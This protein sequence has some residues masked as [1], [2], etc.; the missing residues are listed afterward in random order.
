MVGAKAKKI[1]S[2][3][4]ETYTSVQ[5][6]AVCV[7]GPWVETS[8]K[9]GCGPDYFD[10]KYSKTC[11]QVQ[12][13]LANST[14]K[15]VR[16]YGNYCNMM[17]TWI[18]ALWCGRWRWIHCAV[19][20]SNHKQAPGGKGTS[21][22]NHIRTNSNN[23]SLQVSSSALNLKD[24][25]TFFDVIYLK[26]IGYVLP[27]S[28]FTE[29]ALNSIQSSAICSFIPKCGFNR[30]THRPSFL[31]P[32]TLPALASPPSTLSKMRAKFFSSWSFG[33]LIL[34]PAAFSK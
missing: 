1:L 29:A 10:H 20:P 4:Q 34:P 15:F 25:R 16:G 17:L 5:E 9:I 28:Y 13:F 19:V 30:N 31:D 32:A 26:S 24:S 12:D 3:V 8:Q 14:G 23:M 6:I 7:T 11:R 21:Q 2:R 33:E 27:N 18:I 22:A